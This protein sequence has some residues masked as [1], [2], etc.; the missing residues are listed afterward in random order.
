M[1]R[2]GIP[3]TGNFEFHIV[4]NM[5]KPTAF[6]FLSAILLLFISTPG[7]AQWNLSGNTGTNPSVNFLGTTDNKALK[8]KTNGQDRLFISGGGKI[9]IGMTGPSFK[10][11]VKGNLNLAKDSAYYINSKKTLHTKGNLNVFCGNNSGNAIT[12]G[13]G[14]S[15]FG[16]DALKSDSSGDSNAAF[17]F[18]ALIAN[19]TGEN[20][21]GVGTSSLYFNT[22]GSNNVAVGVSALSGNVSG[23]SN[24][25]VGYGAIYNQASGSFNVVMGCNTGINM[26]SGTGNTLLGFQG[27]FTPSQASYCTLLGFAA[28]M[29]NSLTGATAIGANSMVKQ[30]NSMVLG[31][32]S[33]IRVGIGIT[34]P[35]YRLDVRRGSINTD[36]LYRIGGATVL[37][38]TGTA[39]TLVGN[40]TNQN[41]SGSGNTFT[42]YQSGA[43]NAGGS[44]NAFYGASAGMNNTGGSYN[45]CLG[46]MAGANNN[47]GS[48]NT[49]IGYQ[50]GNLMTGGNNTALGVSAGS[51][52]SGGSGNTFIGSLADARS[53]SLSNA[54][55]LGYN[56]RVG[57]S[58]SLVLG[59]TSNIQVGIGTSLPAAR[60]HI[61]F[62]S[63]GTAPQLLLREQG[64]DYARVHFQNNQTTNYW[65]LAA[66][67]HATP[68]SARMNFFNNGFGDIMVL[69]GNGNVGIGNIV[70]A[71]QLEVGTNSA[72]KPGSSAWTVSSDAR[73]KTQ[74]R[75]F[76][77][78]L[79][80]LEK[81]RPVRFRYNGQA[82]TPTNEDFV[83]TLAQELQEAA[84]YM[85]KPFL[86]TDEKTG[87]Q[88]EFLG[89]DYGAMDFILTN[90]VMELKKELDRK[91]ERISK[92]Q[93]EIDE[94]RQWLLSVKEEMAR[95]CSS[96][97]TPEILQGSATTAPGTEKAF[98]GQNN[99]N[100]FTGQTT[101]CCYIPVTTTHAELKIASAEGKEIR[102]TVITAR[103]PVTCE[104]R[105]TS[106]PGLYTITLFIDGQKA[107]TRQMIVN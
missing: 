48:S 98:L 26:T 83:G 89:V 34:V 1:M 103:G 35:A 56:A 106:A 86:N 66:L 36:S 84:P 40:T 4:H 29:A 57:Q 70:P 12:T 15:A 81:I 6:V 33:T 63:S 59:D 23:N 102:N 80:V 46:S 19:T 3:T 76:T 60:L 24:T 47:T 92:Q 51:A 42:G 14:N 67:A 28:N 96:H 53:S 17:G 25:V 101:I 43:A 9:G 61:D 79:N 64:A 74:V 44:E 58:N 41:N 54:T 55:A 85:I 107:E 105:H 72:A 18:G 8:L 73:L 94:L 78:G 68:A 71:F 27:A 69:T 104:Y 95:C 99:P 88:T 38:V 77:D 39:N 22:T 5:K 30:S 13:Y 31:D 75:D 97:G 20:N 32:T 45:T 65:A 7:H 82:H 93:Q 11:D 90:S 10:L 37:S 2:P 91:E 50:A 16:E 87:K 52:Y 49:L 100:P 21:V 62:N